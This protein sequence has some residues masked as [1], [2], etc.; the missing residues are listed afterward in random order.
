M[1]R[2]LIVLLL[3]VLV[4]SACSSY[5]VP[6]YGLSAENITGLRRLG[7]KVTVGRFT[8]TTPAQTEIRCRASGPVRTPDGRPFEDYIRRALVDELKVA[9]LLSDSAPVTL[10]G[11]L[12]KIDFNSMA[13]DWTMHLTATSSRA[14]LERLEQIRL[15]HGP[16]VLRGRRRHSG[17]R[18]GVRGDSPSVRAGGAGVDRK[19]RAPSRVRR[20]AEVGEHPWRRLDS[21]WPGS[22]PPSSRSQWLAAPAIIGRSPG[23]RPS[24]S[25]GTTRSARARRA[26]TRRRRRTAW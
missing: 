21:P 15:Q 1:L 23:P 7:A 13:G 24:S 19:A 8:A 5:T 10:T 25:T 6:R 9:E 14:L 4:S 26:R 2:Q 12:D 22:S 11:N 20:S 16:R 17:G 18:A 3:A